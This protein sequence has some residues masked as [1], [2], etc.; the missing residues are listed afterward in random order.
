[1]CAIGSEDAARVV[2]CAVLLCVSVVREAKREG[3]LGVFLFFCVI[4]GPLVVCSGFGCG[5]TGEEVW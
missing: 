5:T 1:M 4:T 3:A 2:R